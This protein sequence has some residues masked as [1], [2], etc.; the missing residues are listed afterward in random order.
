MEIRRIFYC[1]VDCLNFLKVNKNCHG[2]I[3]AANILFDHTRNVKLIDSYFVNG[4]KTAYEIVMENPSSM[5]L[6]SPEQL[7]NIKCRQ[8]EN[9]AHIHETEM[10]A[11]GLVML[12]AMTYESAME[13]YNLSTLSLK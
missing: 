13:C 8:T 2:D 3:K 4:G 1:V 6:L 10:F 9:L 11:V 12:E 5:S 7:E